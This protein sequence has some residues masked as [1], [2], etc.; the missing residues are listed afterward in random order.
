MGAFCTSYNFK[1]FGQRNQWNWEI[2]VVISDEFG[3]THQ[4]NHLHSE[5]LVQTETHELRKSIDELEC[6]GISTF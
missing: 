6:S 1:L 5:I 3:P 2:E 4:K